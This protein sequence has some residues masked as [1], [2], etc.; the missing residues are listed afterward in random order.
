MTDRNSRSK[1]ADEPSVDEILASIRRIVFEDDGAG[2][3]PDTDLAEA[4]IPSGQVPAAR[5]GQA[6][7]DSAARS[8][9]EAVPPREPPRKPARK[10][11]RDGET[12][13]G[14]DG[15]AEEAPPPEP[16]APDGPPDRPEIAA[17]PA[18][19][20]AVSSDPG[21]DPVA[22][23]TVLLLTD[24]IAPDGSVVRIA[25]RPA[26]APL[27]DRPPAPGVKAS[28]AEAGGGEGVGEGT[29]DPAA[30]DRLAAAV[31]EWLDR[32]APGMV[33]EAARRELQKLDERQ[34]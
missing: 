11:L 24:M 26:E 22:V 7:R 15:R 5:A 31:R 19:G 6:D 23:D 30:Q 18:A 2:P 13:A 4:E 3:A 33:D 34:A 21:P 8:A 27:R 25:P 28:E 16:P 12:A 17:G 20:D 14:E 9:G 32:N 10:L 29:L 1:Q